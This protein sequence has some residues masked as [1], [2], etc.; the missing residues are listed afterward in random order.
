MRLPKEVEKVLESRPSRANGKSDM[1]VQ[2]LLAAIEKDLEEHEQKNKKAT[3]SAEEI[4]AAT[5]KKKVPKEERIPGQKR[6]REK[7]S[8]PGI[9]TLQD[10]G[11]ELKQDPKEMR[12]ILRS[13]FPKPSSGRWEWDIND[14]VLAKIRKEF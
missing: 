8:K 1:E 7:E 12:K 3:R 14:P 13:K 11:K 2:R 6:A 5:A 10:L 4:I 9:I